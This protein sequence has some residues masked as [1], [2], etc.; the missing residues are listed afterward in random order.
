MLLSAVLHYDP[1]SRR[2]DALITAVCILRNGKGHTRHAGEGN[3]E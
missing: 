2:L 1:L 3:D